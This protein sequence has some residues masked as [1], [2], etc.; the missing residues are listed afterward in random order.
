MAGT[1]VGVA[2][3][4]SSFVGTKVP[5]EISKMIHTLNSVTIDKATF[6]AIVAGTQDISCDLGFCNH[7]HQYV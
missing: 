7:H 4:K 5:D 1:V 2:A 3:D 6:R